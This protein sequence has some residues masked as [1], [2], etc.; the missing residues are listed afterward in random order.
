MTLEDLYNFQAQRT[1][2]TN[3]Q[4][5]EIA[6]NVL[7][8]YIYSCA[9]SSRSL[10]QQNE[11]MPMTNLLYSYFNLKK[12]KSDDLALLDSIMKKYN[13][14]Y[15]T[16]ACNALHYLLCNKEE[17]VHK[18]SYQLWPAIISYKEENN[19]FQLKTK[20]GTIRFYKASIYFK[21]TDL[22]PI[23]SRKLS[24]YCYARTYDILKKRPN[25]TKAIISYMPNFFCGGYYHNYVEMAEGI[26]DIASNC[27]YSNLKEAN[28]ILN[29][30]IIKKVSY[31]EIEDDYYKLTK[32]IPYIDY[33]CQQDKL[34]ALSVYY[35]YQKHH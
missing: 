11:K 7:L 12:A 13:F 3:F 33:A 19:F 21:N 8:E 16:S 26:L 17:L 32:K 15:S 28:K 24:G 9:Y 29:G 1:N 6:R 23:F 4:E 27:F 22:D 5:N 18:V 14:N 25:D 35:D 20:I 30:Q 2:I 10:L 34:N 31:E